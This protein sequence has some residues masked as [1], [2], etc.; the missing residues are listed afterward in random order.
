MDIRYFRVE[1][2]FTFPMGHRLSKHKGA[3]ANI[4]GHNVTLLVGVK[5]LVLNHND[6]V[7]DFHDLKELVNPL[8]KQWDHS[9]ILNATDKP[10][11]KKS[12]LTHKAFYYD[13]DPTA[14]KLSEYLY[15][16]ID[17]LLPIGVKMDYI[18][19]YENENSMATYSVPE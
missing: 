17:K 10:V 3:C 12:V 5:S 11:A 16:E 19:F 9:L 13:F 14:E 8:V 15:H 4:H 18:K 1:R 7:I 6:M 2:K